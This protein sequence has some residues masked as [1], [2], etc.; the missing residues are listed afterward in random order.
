MHKILIIEDEDSILMPLE[1]D[2]KL[3]GYDVSSARDGLEGFSMAKETRYDLIILDLMLPGM[4]GFDVCKQLRESGITTPILIL[5]AKSQEIDKVLGL[6]LGADDYVTKP[7]SPR[8]L[9]ARVKAI[10]RR[11][12]QT[13]KGI[14]FYRFG[15]V[16]V[17]FVKYEAQKEGNLV[18]LTSLEFSLLHYLIQHKDEVVSRD[19]ILNEVWGE[20]VYVFPRTVDTHVAHLRKKIEDDPSDPRHILGVRGVG[21]KFVE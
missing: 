18:Y 19:S 8:E 7:F 1:D 10:L 9:Q 12:Q 13:R 5:S 4:N 3:E 17:D 21:Y 15:D 20:D 11:V 16:D 6:E 2:L 14:D